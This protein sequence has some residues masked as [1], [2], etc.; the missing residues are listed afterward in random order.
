MN[1]D[2]LVGP[3]T[4][5]Y[6]IGATV[7]GIWWASDLSTRMATAESNALTFKVDITGD[8]A[9]LRAADAR[10]TRLETLIGHVDKQ[11]DRI[12]TKLDRRADLR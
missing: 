9:A 8:I 6:L 12:E 11:L 3:G 1:W 5:V 4:V 10:I 7:A 2:K